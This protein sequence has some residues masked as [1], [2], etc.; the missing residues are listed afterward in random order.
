MN[1]D[2]AVEA[3]RLAI[4]RFSTGTHLY[5]RSV[6]VEA[7]REALA[8]VRDVHRRFERVGYPGAD[9]RVVCSHCL[10]PVDWPCATARLVYSAEELS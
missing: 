7:A 4:S 2:P 1:G 3:A 6:A 10:G 5:P 8:P 9:G